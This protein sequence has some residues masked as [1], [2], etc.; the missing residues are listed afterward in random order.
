MQLGQKGGQKLNSGKQTVGHSRKLRDVRRQLN[1]RARDS[2]KASRF[3]DR[4]QKAAWDAM[5]TDQK[6]RLIREAAGNGYRGVYASA[7]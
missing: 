7:G 5:P 2:R 6:Q 4:E 1:I 3:M